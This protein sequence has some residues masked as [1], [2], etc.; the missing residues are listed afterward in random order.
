M[1]I[2]DTVKESLDYELTHYSEWRSWDTEATA[3]KVW[4]YLGQ[5]NTLTWLRGR[6]TWAQTEA[7]HGAVMDWL[8]MFEPVDG[9][10]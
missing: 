7:V 2:Y 9:T 4:L 5:R 6:E 8:G 10:C 1:F 3:R